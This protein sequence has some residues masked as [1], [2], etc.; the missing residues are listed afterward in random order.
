MT[1]QEKEAKIR[2]A[3]AE[4]EWHEIKAGDSWLIFKIMSE[5]VEGFEK[6]ARIG[7]C[8]S[9]FGSARTKP[10]TK[11]Y[12]LAKEIRVGLAARA[13]ESQQEHRNYATKSEVTKIERAM[14]DDIQA[15]AA[16]ARS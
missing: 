3:F 14:F 6:M 7:P 10:G 1:N 16:S 2:R 13:T 15:I 11:Y 5:F 9:V 12:E 4:K 8:V